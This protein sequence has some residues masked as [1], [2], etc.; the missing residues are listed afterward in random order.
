MHRTHHNRKRLSC[1]SRFII[2]GLIKTPFYFARISDLFVQ[3]YDRE[4]VR[5]NHW[6]ARMVEISFSRVLRVPINIWSSQD[7]ILID[8]DDV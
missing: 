4:I 5:I 8:R 7:H 6:G 2:G 3:F 1:E